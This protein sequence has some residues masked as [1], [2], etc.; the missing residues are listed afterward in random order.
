MK[1]KWVQTILAFGMWLV[2]FVLGVVFLIVSR[3]SLINLLYLYYAQGKFQRMKEVQFL[4]PAYFLVVGIALLIAMIVVEE[5]FRGGVK[6]N[7]L[8]V[9]FCRVVGPELGFVFL[10]TLG[11]AFL[12][13]FG[14]EMIALMFLEVAAGAVMIWYG[15]IK[16]NAVLTK[17]N[18]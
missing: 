11:A 7:D 10:A 15:Y 8:L 16:R 9:R 2:F 3:T 17:L 13:G 14:F 6:K 1:T 4:N 12:A 18:S 5:Y